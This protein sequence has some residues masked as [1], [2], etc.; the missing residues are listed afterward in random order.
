ML[1]SFHQGLPAFGQVPELVSGD[2]VVVVPVFLAEGYY[3]RKV[4]P[5]E[6]LRTSRFR[7]L[8]IWLTP[9]VGCD[10]RLRQALLERVRRLVPRLGWNPERTA[11]VVLG[12][13]TPRSATSSR[14]THEV[15]AFLR[16]EGPC[17]TVHAAF[18]DE[19]PTPR[20]ALQRTDADHCLVLPWLFGGGDHAG[21]LARL[22]GLGAPWRGD[23]PESTGRDSEGRD[24]VIDRPIGED[25]VLAEII[26]DL[27]RFPAVWKRLD[28]GGGVAHVN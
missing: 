26:G 13:G 4:L 14:T 12:H 2:A 9:V 19:R 5:R 6:L 20:E 16:S 10:S 17:K 22:F 11:V 7:P 8:D 21:E 25:P 15:T 24:Y 18:L 27:A 28:S 23:S 3:S 1:T